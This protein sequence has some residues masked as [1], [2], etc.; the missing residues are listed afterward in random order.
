MRPHL[1]V[2]MPAS[3]ASD[4]IRVCERIAFQIQDSRI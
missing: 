3:D 1:T 2:E 4:R